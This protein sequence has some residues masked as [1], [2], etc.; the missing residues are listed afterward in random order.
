[1]DCPSVQFRG[2]HLALYL[3]Q[4]NIASQ[5]IPRNRCYVVVC[6][7]AHVLSNVGVCFAVAVAAFAGGV[8][9]ASVGV[10]VTVA[11]AAS[12]IVVVVAVVVVGVAA[13]TSAVAVPVLLCCL[14]ALVIAAM[15]HCDNTVSKRYSSSATQ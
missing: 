9:I 6:L 7:W 15:Q 13:G 3:P 8:V 2:R 14:V 5:S 4:L 12:A 10:V 11:A 1:M